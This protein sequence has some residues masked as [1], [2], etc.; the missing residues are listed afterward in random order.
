VGAFATPLW[1]LAV[2]PTDLPLRD[3]CAVA[4][5]GG[6]AGFGATDWRSPAVAL[7]ARGDFLGT[8]L[9]ALA[10]FASAINVRRLLLKCLFFP[11]SY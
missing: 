7:A 5:A 8:F 2:A 1:P 9:P 6:A 3:G 11:P 10:A 4:W